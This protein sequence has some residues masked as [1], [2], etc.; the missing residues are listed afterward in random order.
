[1]GHSSIVFLVCKVILFQSL[2]IIYL[3]IRWINHISKSISA[4]DALNPL[5]EHK[6]LHL[7]D[8]AIPVGVTCPHGV[9]HRLVVVGRSQSHAKA[10]IPVRIVELVPLELPRAV[11]VVLHVDHVDVVSQQLVVV[12][13]VP[14]AAVVHHHVVRHSRVAAAH[15]PPAV[16][17]E[18]T[19]IV[20]VVMVV[21]V[22]P[23]SSSITETAF[24]SDCVPC[25]NPP[26][27]IAI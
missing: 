27:H 10:Q 23:K 15:C 19:A 21:T 17:A 13:A 7:T 3:I 6:H 4:V 26:P 12:V 25:P 22:M 16:E 11:V 2:Q 9:P 5:E 20:V 18:E 8:S 24:V 14:S 1:M